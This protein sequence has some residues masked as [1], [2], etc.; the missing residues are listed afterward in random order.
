MQKKWA[1]LLTSAA[2]ALALSAC[3]GGGNESDSNAA[4]EAAASASETLTIKA[5]NW[6]FDQSEYAIPKDTQVEIELLNEEG[7]HG[8]EIEG[9]DVK[10][11]GSKKS[12]VVTL[13][14]GTYTIKCNIMC[15]TGHLNMTA[16]LV[17]Q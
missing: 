10:L 5:S 17:V 4:E 9:A 16:K 12:K 8:I 1:A 6:A 3:G 7:A 15:G 11:D 13:E 2:L 14:A